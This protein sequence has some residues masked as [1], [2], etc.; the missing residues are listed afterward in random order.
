MCA[1]KKNKNPIQEA[2]IK[3]SQQRSGFW[4]VIF[5]EVTFL[6]LTTA[7]WPRVTQAWFRRHLT[8][9]LSSNVKNGM[10]VGTLVAFSW[11]FAEIYTEN[12]QLISK[13]AFKMF[14]AR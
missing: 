8:A 9:I 12:G 2:N 3:I 7:T 5:K 1:P 13:S 10:V 14:A 4:L 6:K 11:F